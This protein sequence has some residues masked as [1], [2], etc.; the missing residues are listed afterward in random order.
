MEFEVLFSSVSIKH[1]NLV[2]HVHKLKL[3][4]VFVLFPALLIKKKSL[5]T[6]P[7]SKMWVGNWNK[8]F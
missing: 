2:Y 4:F 5:P 6:N 3:E 7:F 8:I 1:L